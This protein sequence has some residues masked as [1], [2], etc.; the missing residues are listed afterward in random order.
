MSHFLARQV[1]VT[2]VA[3]LSLVIFVFRCFGSLLVGYSCFFS[4]VTASHNQPPALLSIAQC[5]LQQQGW[6][7]ASTDKTVILTRELLCRSRLCEH[8]WDSW[9]V[10]HKAC[11]FGRESGSKCKISR[12]TLARTRYEPTTLRG[13]RTATSH[14]SGI[15]RVCDNYKKQARH[16]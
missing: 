15:V 10:K 12:T 14:C 5:E 2:A 16:G 4:T 9:S 1:A 8:C 11:T 6:S 13:K 3:V 7:V